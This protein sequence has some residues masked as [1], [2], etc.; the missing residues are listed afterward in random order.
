[1]K[2]TLLFAVLLF[3][4]L[5]LSGCGSANEKSIL[6]DLEKKLD[7]TNAYQVEGDLNIYSNEDEYAYKV[8]VSFQKNKQFRV[9][10]KDKTNNHEQIILRNEDGVYVQAHKSTQ[11]KNLII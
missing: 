5:C 7:N 1:M 4:S 2:K 8:S 11:Q 9:L 6:K 3:G 10:L